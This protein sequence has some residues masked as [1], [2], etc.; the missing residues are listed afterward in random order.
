MTTDIQP[1][2]RMYKYTP[3]REQCSTYVQ[4]GEGFPVFLNVEE[5]VRK[6]GMTQGSLTHDLHVRNFHEFYAR[7]VIRCKWHAFHFYSLRPR[8]HKFYISL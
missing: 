8:F 7:S 2:I 5:T 1:D 3:D 6:G 4:G